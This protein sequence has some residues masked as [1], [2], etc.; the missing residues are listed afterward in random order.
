[1]LITKRKIVLCLFL[2]P[3]RNYT[4]G[5]KEKGDLA[6]QIGFC[7]CLTKVGGRKGLLYPCKSGIWTQGKPLIFNLTIRILYSTS[8]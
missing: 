7:D 4:S 1:M 5:L 3:L 2:A 6:S 8:N